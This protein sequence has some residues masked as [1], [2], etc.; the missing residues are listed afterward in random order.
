V[1]AILV[2]ALNPPSISLPMIDLRTAV[3]LGWPAWLK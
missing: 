2:V 3:E 1:E